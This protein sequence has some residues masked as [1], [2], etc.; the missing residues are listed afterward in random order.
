MRPRDLARAV[1]DRYLQSVN[2]TPKTAP[3]GF[4]GC[5]VRWMVHMGEETRA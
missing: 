4:G 3:M 2:P 5:S 1:P